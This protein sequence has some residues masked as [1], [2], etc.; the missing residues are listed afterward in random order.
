MMRRVHGVAGPALIVALIA[1]VGAR[2]TTLAN[3]SVAKMTRAADAIVHARCV[4]STAAW[5][6][7][8]IWTF[9]TFQSEETWK[10]AVASR[11]TVRLLG[12]RAENITSTV[13]GVPRFQSGEEAILF[14][15]QTMR[16]DYSIISW[17]QG[18]FRIRR[19][20]RTGEEIAAQDTADFATFDP[21]TRRFE[22]D[23]IRSVPL[24]FLRAQ[25]DAAQHEQAGRKP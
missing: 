20:V 10:G 21:A 23:G 7:G 11:F 22:A 17:M 8:E 24:N 25:V 18:T 13:A 2:G 19:D 3:M 15:E 1:C 4:G 9:T 14:L 5:D 6:A 16:G 12:G